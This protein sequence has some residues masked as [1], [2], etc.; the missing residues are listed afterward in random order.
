MT[1]SALFFLLFW[2]VLYGAHSLQKATLALEAHTLHQAIDRS[3]LLNGAVASAVLWALYY[4]AQKQSRAL[5]LVFLSGSSIKLIAYF[6]VIY[7]LFSQDGT[8]SREEFMLFF[9]PYL[10]ALSFQLAFLVCHQKPS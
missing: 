5:L 1:K 2:S 10:I 3:Y 4:L 7:P 9:I 8:T 6:I